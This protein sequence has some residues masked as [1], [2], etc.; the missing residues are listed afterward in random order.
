MAPEVILMRP[1]GT[2]CDVWSVGCVAQEM[3]E[4]LPP[5]REFTMLRLLFRTATVGAQGLRKVWIV[6]RKP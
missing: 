2:A 1:Y 4:L 5:Y 3:S 6:S